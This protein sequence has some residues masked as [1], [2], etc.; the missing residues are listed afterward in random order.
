MSITK[1]YSWSDKTNAVTLF[2]LNGNMRLV[3]EVTTIPYDLLY[4]W[5]KEDWWPQLVEEIRQAKKAKTGT[6]LSTI[7][8]TSLEVIQDRL[9][10]GDFILNN[11]TGAIER[12]PVTLR[13]AAQVTNN[14]LTR[15]LQMEEISDRMNQ[16][17]NTVQ[18]TLTLLAKEFKKMT[19]K[20]SAAESVDVNYKEVTDALDDQRKT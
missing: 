19:N 7:I 11:K 3:S 14:L 17:K 8:D 12:K 4:S 6:K 1:P 5:R 18:E 20:K 13:D 15:Q 2:M 9:E 10:N 16:D